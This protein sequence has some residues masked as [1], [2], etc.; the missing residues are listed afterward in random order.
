MPTQTHLHRW[1]ADVRKR[2]FPDA[3]FA[4]DAIMKDETLKLLSSVG[5]ISSRSLFDNVL[6]GQ[7]LWAEKYGDEVF[8]LLHGLDLPPMKPLPKKP[9]AAKR[10]A[11][12]DVEHEGEGE[13]ASEPKRTRKESAAQMPQVG[14]VASTSSIADA[15]VPTATP[16][17][18]VPSAGAIPRPPFVVPSMGGQQWTPPPG[19]RILTTTYGVTP[20]QTMTYIW[21]H[22]VSDPGA[23]NAVQGDGDVD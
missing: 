19:T 20:I 8:N 3:F 14:S 11:P 23:V 21:P 2:D 1:R 18:A 5:P 16:H 17:N 13:S 6:A 22:A 15:T 9:R 4:S 12:A 10:R 7:W